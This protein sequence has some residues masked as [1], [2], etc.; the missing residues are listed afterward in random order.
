M[1]TIKITYQFN[2]DTEW[3][4][5]ITAALQGAKGSEELYQHFRLPPCDGQI[6]INGNGLEFSL[7]GTLH[8]IQRW[9]KRL[10]QL[11]GLK[12]PN[13][14]LNSKQPSDRTS[15]SA[16]QSRFQQYAA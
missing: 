4:R 5:R 12:A 6:K 16:N 15:T 3:N 7:T 1:N 2:Q 8:S 11:A 9:V 14:L 10:E 13:K